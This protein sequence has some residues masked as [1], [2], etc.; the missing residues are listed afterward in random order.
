ME[1]YLTEL[2]NENCNKSCFFSSKRL[3]QGLVISRGAWTAAA[4]LQACKAY[5]YHCIIKQSTY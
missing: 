4:S 1:K 5:V 2:N 3:R